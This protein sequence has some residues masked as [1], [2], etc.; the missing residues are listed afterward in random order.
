LTTAAFVVLSS[1][2]LSASA[3]AVEPLERSA[4][5]CLPGSDHTAQATGRSLRGDDHRK[6]SERE[7]REMEQSLDRALARQSS[8]QPA[9]TGAAVVSVP[10]HVHVIDGNRFRGPSQP[11]VRAQLKILNEAFAGR[12]SQ[13][14]APT[15]YSFSLSSFHRVRNQTWLKADLYDRASLEMGRRLHRGGTDELNMYFSKPKPDPHFGPTLGWSS[16]PS[17]ASRNLKQ[18][19]VTIN[20]G[21]MQGGVYPGYDDGDTA[22][23]EVGHWL[24]LYHTFQGGCAIQNDRVKD[25]PRE[26]RPSLKCQVGRDTCSAPGTDPVRNFMDYSYDT[27]MNMFTAGQVTRMDENWQGFRARS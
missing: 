20:V 10:V 3:S 11:E 21:S 14:S 15:G 9:Q 17:D 2:G 22:V 25:T 13:V 18:D 23:H 8:S 27:C 4:P 7:V 6:L 19:G 1:L 26:Q 24:G 5:I 16:F 12:Q